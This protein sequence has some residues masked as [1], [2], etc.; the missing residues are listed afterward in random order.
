MPDPAIQAIAHSAGFRIGGLAGDKAGAATD[1]GS[2]SGI[3][4]AGFG[5]ALSHA[6]EGLVKEQYR[7]RRAVPGARARQDRRHRRRGHGRG[8][9]EPLDAARRAGAEQGGRRVPRD[10]PDA[11][12]GGP[13]GCLASPVP[14]SSGAASSCALRLRWSRAPW[15]CSRPAT[16]S[17]RWRRSRA[18]RSW[19][20]ASRPPRA[21]TSPTR[22]RAPA[23]RYELRDGGSTVAV[24]S[25]D[26]T[27]A[28]VQLA[29]DNL[30]NGGQHGFELF[31]S[32]SLGATDFEQK[33]KYQRALEG[34]IGRTIESVDGVRSAQ[35]QLVLP[36]QSLFLD[37]GT[38]ASAA[39]LLQSGGATRRQRRLRDR[40][41]R[42]LERR[43]PEGGRRHDHRRDRHAALAER[44]RRRGHLDQPSAG[45]AAVLEHRVGAD[46][47]DARLDARPRQGLRAACTPT[48]T[49]TSRRSNP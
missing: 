7:R 37:E 2:A 22:S 49:S 32:K 23:S 3:G 28:R 39:V 48:S 29:Q 42:L 15:R 20:A 45:G 47:R 8:A 5:H 43:G 34:E 33:V 38:H 11:D 18:T 1:P 9:R 10:L 6:I 26:V 14:P 31:D 16:S 41:P 12:L 36:K 44:Q 4:G 21:A 35:V 17:S 46:R 24:Q 30:P 25:S 27:R 13:D 40:T 19:R